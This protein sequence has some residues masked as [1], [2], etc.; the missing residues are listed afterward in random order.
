MSIIIIS[1]PHERPCPKEH[2]CDHHWNMFWFHSQCQSFFVQNNHGLQTMIWDA[3]WVLCSFSLKDVHNVDVLVNMFSWRRWR[4]RRQRRMIPLPLQHRKTHFCLQTN[5]TLKNHF[6]E[7][8]H[9]Q[10]NN[11]SRKRSRMNQRFSTECTGFYRCTSTGSRIRSK[12]ADWL[13]GLTD[14]DPGIPIKD[15]DLDANQNRRPTKSGET[16]WRFYCPF[17]FRKNV[18][19]WTRAIYTVW[20]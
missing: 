20:N 14:S 8:C 2:K 11:R 19:D 10:N 3:F 9:Q 5:G 12:I 13:D 18:T 17:K 15:P 6:H 16:W 7:N 4:W 1:L